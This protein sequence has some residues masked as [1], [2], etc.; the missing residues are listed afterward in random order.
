MEKIIENETCEKELISKI[1]KQLTQFNM[2]KNKQPNQKVGIR[3]KQTF[4]QRRHIGDQQTWKDAQC[5]SLFSS[6]QLLSHV[7][8]FATCESQHARPPYPSPTPGVS[9]NSCP[10]SQ[11]CRPSISSSV[12]PFSSCPQSFPASE[13]FPMS[14]L[15]AWGG[16]SNGVSASASVL[17]MNTWDWSLL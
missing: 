9:S 3:S 11:W 6:V 16:Q 5:H 15:F 4:L 1:Y 14:Q 12:I 10:L 2:R 7:W 13:S 8:L 17:P